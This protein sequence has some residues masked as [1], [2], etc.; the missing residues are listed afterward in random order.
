[1]NMIMTCMNLNCVVFN[2]DYRL[3]PEHKCPGPSED[4]VDFMEYVLSN[5]T[6]FGIDTSRVCMAGCSGGGW[7]CVGAANL[8]AKKGK[9][10]M[11][12]A[13]F[14]HTGMVSNET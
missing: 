2:L 10:S 8:L 4:Y 14:V 5:P 12:K 1:M 7:V 13:M 3:A 11:V 9:L 6:K